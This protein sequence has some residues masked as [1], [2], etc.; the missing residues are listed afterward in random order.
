MYWKRSVGSLYL[1]VYLKIAPIVVRSTK[2]RNSLFNAKSTSAI[3]A[4]PIAITLQI[5]IGFTKPTN[6]DTRAV[7]SRVTK[8]SNIETKAKILP[9]IKFGETFCNIV[10]IVI[11]NI[12]AKIPIPASHN[13][14]LKNVVQKDIVIKHKNK[15]RND[16]T[17]VLLVF[18][19]FPK[20]NII[21]KP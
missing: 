8:V 6:A 14:A 12:E 5:V 18:M 3:E 2:Y 16:V 20:R 13:L 1:N 4:H 11:F 15:P 17:R 19:N 7:P 10:S 9:L 21:T